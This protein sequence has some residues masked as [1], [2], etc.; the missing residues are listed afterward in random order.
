MNQP[1]PRLIMLLGLVIFLIGL[2]LYLAAR[3][4]LP[5][6]RLPGD[7]R[8]EFGNFKLFIPLTTMLIISL[9]ITLAINL[10]SSF[11]NR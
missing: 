2:G 1:L 7:I 6:G 4:N 9:I 11:L 8:I 3:F 5:I 10:I